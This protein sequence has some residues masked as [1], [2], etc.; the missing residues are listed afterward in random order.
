MIDATA[1]VG[2]RKPDLWTAANSRRVGDWIAAVVEARTAKG[3]S[4]TGQKFQPYDPDTV[5]QK[6]TRRVTLRQTG[7]MLDT[8]KVTP[9]A[10]G[11]EVAATV[12]YARFVEADR[13]FL[14][15]TDT[16]LKALD[17]VVAGELDRE[18]ARIGKRVVRGG[19]VL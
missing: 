11:V 10:R 3:I 4:A 12:P 9:T 13:P 15:L 6:R 16:E 17:Q 14:G 8:L 2:A 7:R 19:A 18:E 5:E 1:T